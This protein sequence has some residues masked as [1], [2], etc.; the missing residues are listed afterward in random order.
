MSATGAWVL[1][2]VMGLISLVG[3]F[4]ASRAH[5]DMFYIVGLLLFLFGVLFNFGLIRRC[6][7]LPHRVGT[8]D[9]L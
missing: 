4:M 1:G 3:L 6:T 2:G 8:T 5:D 7:G 9:Y